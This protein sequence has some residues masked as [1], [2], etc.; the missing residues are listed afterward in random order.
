M[1][2]PL[3]ELES[4]A[5]AAT[6]DA[7]A[8]A[9]ARRNDEQRAAR[10][11]V[12]KRTRKE[13]SAARAP[14]SF[15]SSMRFFGLAGVLLIGGVVGAVAHLENA[16]MPW[17]EIAAAVG[18]WAAV[19]A[20]LALDNATWRWRLPFRVTG[21]QHIDGSDGTAGDYAPWIA[22]RV[23]I[24]TKG[25]AS[26]RAH[27]AKVLGILESRA[28]KEGFS[29]KDTK[30]GGAQV[31][32]VHENGSVAGQG[33]FAIYTTRIIERWLRRE[34]RLLA[35]VVPVEKVVV[36]AKYTGSGYRLPSG[37]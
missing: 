28:N 7:Q 4:S 18:A 5:A 16:K 35:R 24:V 22:F 27:V 31:W 29:D 8:A 13:R 32:R 33:T 36:S 3:R 17:P 20:L 21:Y 1:G 9:D 10:Q 6:R 26:A 23:E 19:V 15:F 12:Q 14:I 2:D 34:V 30:Y 37:D 25:D 11:T